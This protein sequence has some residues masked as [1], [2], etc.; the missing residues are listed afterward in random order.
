M[1][2]QLRQFRSFRF[3]LFLSKRDYFDG[4]NEIGSLSI[5]RCIA[6]DHNLTGVVDNMTIFFAQNT[7]RLPFFKECFSN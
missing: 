4:K 2:R 6:R 7:R 5:S 1:F 3:V